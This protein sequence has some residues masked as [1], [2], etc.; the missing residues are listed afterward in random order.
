[1]DARTLQF[2]PAATHIIIR[3]TLAAP[4]TNEGLVA[5]NNNNPLFV[6]GYALR[7]V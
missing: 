1:M 2:V 7:P 3:M 5:Y 6:G 4:P